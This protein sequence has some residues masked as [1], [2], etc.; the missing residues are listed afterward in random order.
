MTSIIG[1]NV[2]LRYLKAYDAHVNYWQA[3]NPAYQLAFVDKADHA[4]YI[5]EYAAAL[6]NSMIVARIHH[7]IDGGFHTKPSG[8]NDTRYYVSAPAEYHEAYGWLGRIDNVILNVMNEPAGDSDNDTINRLVHWMVGYIGVAAREKTKSVLFNWGDRNPRIIDGLMDGRF[9]IVL[10]LM[11]AHPELFYFGMHLYGPDEITSHL[12]SYVKR[13]EKLGIT[14]LRVIVTEFG[15]DKTDGKQNGYVSRG[16]SGG[17]YAAWQISQVQHELAPYIKSGLLVGLNVF[18]EGNSGGW[19]AFDIENDQG[20]KKELKRAALAGELEPVKKP[21]T[22]PFIT[23]MPKPVDVMYPKRIRVT[24]V[25]GINLRS[26]AST[27]Y[28]QAGELKKGDEV[29]LYDYPMRQASNKSAWRWV[30]VNETVGG[31]VCTD[32]LS[33]DSVVIPTPVVTTTPLPETP[34][35]IILPPSDPTAPVSI[36]SVFD[37]VPI[38]A[39]MA[40]MMTASERARALSLLGQLSDLFAGLQERAVNEGAKAA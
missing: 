24:N 35:V 11:A 10:Q 9:D 23:P 13:C 30:D 19:E 18:Q 31:W 14:P 12:E 2:A 26:G 17:M 40:Y 39:E 16:Y 8:P 15:F 27:D 6:N 34:V 38:T 21:V 4:P 33:Y 20:Y 29:T 5:Q 1:S 28:Q 32:V 36:P 37:Q 3:V 7:D 22:K 25:N